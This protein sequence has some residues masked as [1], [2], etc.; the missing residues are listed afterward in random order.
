MAKYDDRI[1]NYQLLT[2]KII[3][4]TIVEKISK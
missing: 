3:T 4:K 2:N 1:I